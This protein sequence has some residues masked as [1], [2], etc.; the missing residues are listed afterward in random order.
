MDGEK[1][2]IDEHIYKNNGGKSKSTWKI[3]EFFS[4][5]FACV[6]VYVYEL[7]YPMAILAFVYLV[8]E[9]GY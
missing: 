3:I 6:Y 9:R 1:K 2:T 5:F 4:S 7:C 8:N